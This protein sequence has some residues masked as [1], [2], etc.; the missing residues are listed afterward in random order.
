MLVILLTVQFALS[1]HGNQIAGAVAR[2]AA[3]VVRA[4]GGT[5]SA[6]AA[7]RTRAI[8]YATAIGGSALTDVNV[9]VTSPAAREVRVA[10]SGRSV[11]IVPGFAPRVSK[12]VQGPIEEFRPDLSDPA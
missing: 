7:A 4:G 6:V 10:V 12:S 3:R 11:E 1:W 9:E 5:P 8:D 2:E